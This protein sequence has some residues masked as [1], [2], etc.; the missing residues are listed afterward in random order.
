MNEA[1][2]WLLFFRP[3]RFRVARLFQI[4]FYFYFTH[5]SR[6][7]HLIRQN[8]TV[9]RSFPMIAFCFIYFRN[10]SF[11]VSSPPFDYEFDP[12]ILLRY[13][14]DLFFTESL[15]NIPSI[16]SLDGK[17]KFWKKQPP[18]RVLF[19]ATRQNKQSTSR[20]FTV[21][22]HKMRHTCR[23][24]YNYTVFEQAKL[25]FD[26]NTFIINMS[27]QQVNKKKIPPKK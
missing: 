5:L 26:N 20:S 25:H 13:S 17:Q 9:R 12:M 10:R 21:L 14:R 18:T 4:H 7:Q 2:K 8:F 3:G 15:T 6:I 22:Q 24:T 23:T 1:A 27:A 11:R 16:N 19:S